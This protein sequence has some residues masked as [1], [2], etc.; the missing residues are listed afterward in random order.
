VDMAR[1]AAEK[2]NRPPASVRPVLPDVP[3]SQPRSAV[4]FQLQRQEHDTARSLLMS[5]VRTWILA[6]HLPQRVIADRLQVPRSAVSDI[7]CS[8]SNYAAER[9]LELWVALGGHW[10]LR[11][12]LGD[13]GDKDASQRT[14]R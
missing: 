13:P 4:T 1:R 6:Q 11:L 5:A 3:I 14:D 7:I 10:E 9:L 12:T 2:T 8:K